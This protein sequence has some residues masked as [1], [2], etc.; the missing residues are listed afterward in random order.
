QDLLRRERVWIPY[1]LVHL[2]FTLP[3]PPGSGCFLSSSNGLA[4]GN[5]LLEAISHAVCEVVER[6]ADT[7]FHLR[8][9]EA[10][11]AARIDLTTVDDPGCREVLEKCARAGIAVAAWETTSDVGIPAFQCLL[12]DRD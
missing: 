5:H 7:L 3:R 2:D 8:A 1:E 6:D 4:S 12:L 10:Q 11:Q 9:S